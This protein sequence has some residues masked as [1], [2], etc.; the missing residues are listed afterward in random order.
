MKRSN[1]NLSFHFRDQN[2]TLYSIIPFHSNVSYLCQPSF[3]SISISSSKVLI[4]FLFA[5][6]EKL[7]K[8][9]FGGD[10]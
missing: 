9:G 3:I 1:S 7:R 10:L 8:R 2:D 5:G 4:S 6:N